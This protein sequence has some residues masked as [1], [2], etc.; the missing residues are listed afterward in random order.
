MRKRKEAGSLF[1]LFL[2]YRIADLRNKF[3]RVLG[4]VWTDMV[5]VEH[6]SCRFITVRFH[7]RDDCGV[8]IRNQGVTSLIGVQLAT[9]TSGSVWNFTCSVSG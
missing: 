9:I 1:I 8:D 3:V 5:E 6:W 4:L 2:L 7:P